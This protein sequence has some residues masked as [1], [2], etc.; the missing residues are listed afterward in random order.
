[1]STQTEQP[2]TGQPSDSGDCSARPSV[3][4]LLDCL[5][6]D[7]EHFRKVLTDPARLMEKVCRNAEHVASR[8]GVPAWSVIGS[9]TGHG[10]GVASAIYELYRPRD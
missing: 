10:S 3:D 7:R 1:M 2:T 5:R 6:G 4:S 9:W 8:K